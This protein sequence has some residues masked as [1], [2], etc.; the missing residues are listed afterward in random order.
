MK[1]KLLKQ[2]FN[3][4]QRAIRH[5]LNKEHDQFFIHAGSSFELLGKARLAA[6]HPSLIIDR[7]FDSL[8]H[9]C[10]AGKHSK[11]PPWNVKT[12]SATEV[13]DRCTQLDPELKVFSARLKLLAEYRNSI[14]HLGEVP[15]VEVKQL[16]RSYLA[17]SSLI[18][19]SLELKPEEVFGEFAE[20]VSQELNEALAEVHVLVAEKLAQAR[21]SFQQRYS[22]LDPAQ[23]KALINVIESG[24]K[25]GMEKYRDVLEECPAC[26]NVGIASG[27][28]DL[29]WDIDYDNGI[30]IGGSPIVTLNPSDFVCN[31]CGL[32]LEDA[33]ELTAAG[34]PDSIN[35]EDVD[36]S[37]FYEEADPF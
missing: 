14:I 5:Y 3:S 32:K 25:S 34:L 36:P 23:L 16:F 1:E 31:V 6:I 10:A 19:K 4:T 28:Y 29:D 11:R 30:P 8:L 20:M 22:A 33:T 12:I 24:Y 27:D 2:G 35:I 18:L 9:A 13:L 15:E 26:Q 21:D 17:G 7:D 37:D